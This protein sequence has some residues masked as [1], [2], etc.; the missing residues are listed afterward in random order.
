M[1]EILFSMAQVAS[2]SQPEASVQQGRRSDQASH[3]ICWAHPGHTQGLLL[4][5]PF[6]MHWWFSET[7]SALELHPPPPIMPHSQASGHSL[8]SLPC[9]LFPHTLNSTCW[10][11]AILTGPSGFCVHELFFPGLICLPILTWQPHTPSLSLFSRARVL[12]TL[13]FST[14]SSSGL[15]K[16][17]HNL[18]DLD[19]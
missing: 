3:R 2:W 18:R 17:L 1:K 8:P 4:S 11:Q 6:S 12:I 7:C 9:Q 16:G 13:F 10:A 15:Q 14:V 5:A 19:Q